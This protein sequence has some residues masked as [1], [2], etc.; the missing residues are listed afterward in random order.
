MS[1]RLLAGCMLLALAL[2]HSPPA[3]A[4]PPGDEAAKAAPAPVAATSGRPSVDEICRTLAHA[5]ADNDLPEEFFTRSLYRA[6]FQT[7]SITGKLPFPFHPETDRFWLAPDGKSVL[8]NLGGRTL[9]V[10]PLEYL[11]F[12]QTAKLTPLTYLGGVFYSVS[13]LP[14]WAQTLSYVNPILYMV[15]AF[16]HGFLGT[17]DVDPGFAFMIMGGAKTFDVFPTEQQAVAEAAK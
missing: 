14:P 17:S 9:F 7:W 11:D 6:Q 13:L 4:D 10:Y 2:P 8:F 16:R 3:R 1:M 12:Y 5:A 15:N